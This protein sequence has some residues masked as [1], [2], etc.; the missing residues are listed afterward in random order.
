MTSAPR[1][2]ENLLCPSETPLA[3]RVEMTSAPRGDENA[4]EVP[5]GRVDVELRV[6]MTSAPRGDENWPDSFLGVLWLEL[7]EMTSAPRGDENGAPMRSSCA[8]TLC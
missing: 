8:F 3:F 6:E 7:V 1:G 2:D 4:Q 5:R